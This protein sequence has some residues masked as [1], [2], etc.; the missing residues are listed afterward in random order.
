MK[1]NICSEPPVNVCKIITA[2]TT[3]MFLPYHA[4]PSSDSKSNK[5]FLIFRTESAILRMLPACQLGSILC[6]M[7]ISFLGSIVDS[8]E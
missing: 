1:T 4:P 5:L 8:S 2:A 6:N 7:D 3:L